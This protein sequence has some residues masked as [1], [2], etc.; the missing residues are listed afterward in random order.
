[1][2]NF[3]WFILLGALAGW[4]AGTL[5]KG[6]GFGL[7]GNIIVGIIGAVIGGWLFDYLDIKSDGIIGSLVTAVIGALVLIGI[8]SLLSRRR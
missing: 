8:V 6:R 2:E 5:A 1:M 4:I 7:I 3:I